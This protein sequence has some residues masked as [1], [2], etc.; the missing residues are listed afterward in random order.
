MSIIALAI[1]E[2]AAVV[3]QRVHTWIVL[4]LVDTDFIVVILL[5]KGVI[6]C[7]Y[8]FDTYCR[9][10]TISKSI[11]I[12]YYRLYSIR[13]FRYLPICSKRLFPDIDWPEAILGT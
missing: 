3:V 2:T 5:R 7:E 4:I 12:P 1:E 9:L 10:N 8:L 13:K 11:Y 6:V